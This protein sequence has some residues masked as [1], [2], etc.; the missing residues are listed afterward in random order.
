[1]S[2]P[3][4]LKAVVPMIVVEV[5]GVVKLVRYIFKFREE[6]TW[7]LIFGKVRM[8]LTPEFAVLCCQRGR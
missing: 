6:A 5:A 4:V 2:H 1:M 7:H 3:S 8:E